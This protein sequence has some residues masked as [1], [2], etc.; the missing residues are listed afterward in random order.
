MKGQFIAKDGK[1]TE[2]ALGTNGRLER[3]TQSGVTMRTLNLKRAVLVFLLAGN[4]SIG[5]AQ[6]SGTFTPTGDMSFPRV[7]HTATLLATAK[8]TVF[9]L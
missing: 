2:G 8:S 4:S 6:L 9:K 7:F 3:H 1:L 5:L